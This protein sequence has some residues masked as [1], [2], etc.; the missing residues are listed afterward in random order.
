[1]RI[2]HNIMAM[3]SYRNLGGNNTRLSKNLE[4]L[5]SGYRINRAGDD[6]AGLAISE[7]MRAQIAGLDQAQKNA[8]SGINLVKT[9][10]GALTEVHD[11]LNRMTTLASQSANGTYSNTDRQKLQA[12]V[13]ALTEE[14]NRIAENSNFN[15]TK[16]LD[17]SLAGGVEGSSKSVTADV[18]KMGVDVVADAYDIDAVKG[19][20]LT[21][22]LTASPLALSSS[23]DRY[24]MTV[25]FTDVNG[26][27]QSVE[28]SLFMKSGESNFYLDD[29]TEAGE[30]LSATAANFSSLNAAELDA[31][32]KEALTENAAIKSN[33]D[34]TTNTAA[35]RFQFEAKEKGTDGAV[36]HSVKFTHFDDD[37]KET[38][39]SYGITET[40]TKITVSV[41]AVD[42]MKAYDFADFGKIW[43]SSLTDDVA[44]GAGAADQ[45][46]KLEDAIFEVNGVK[47]AFVD[48]GSATG[49]TTDDAEA[50]KAA[51]VDHWIEVA[52]D[53]VITAPDITA[54]VDKIKK[55]TGLSA[56]QG[57]ADTT[58]KTWTKGIGTTDLDIILKDGQIKGAGVEG[59]ELK[60][61]IGADAVETIGVGIESMKAKDLGIENLNISDIESA[62]KSIETI[63][64]AIEQ[65]SVTR[66]NLG[67][68]QNRLEHTINNLGVMEENIQD[69]ESNIRDTDVADEMMAYTKNNILIQSAQAMLAQANQV[70][71]GVLQLMG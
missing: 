34:V 21:D 18:S 15:G 56:E 12:E 47:F 41:E 43:D 29:G 30:K 33:F 2:Q 9:A 49:L 62:N 65:V 38:G 5:S 32:F 66:G 17:G 6:A 10:E 68:I 14:I 45:V 23:K 31:A 28:I 36:L 24:T 67:A 1:M 13:D 20:Y 8:Q 3:N 55:E 39:P 22:A 71:Q 48:R 11:M 35:G 19:A 50:L 58:N 52:T 60:L 54:L 46:A 51:G 64:S 44:G 61:Q 57:T 25:N 69:A 42:E 4:K 26:K 63:K 59:N 7:K 53:G 16:L 37:A 27:E 40:A 70:P